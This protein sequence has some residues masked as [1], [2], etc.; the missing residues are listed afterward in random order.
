MLFSQS[1]SS[2]SMSRFWPG[3][4]FSE[5]T[6]GIV[7]ISSNHD[8]GQS[9]GNGLADL[10]TNSRLQSRLIPIHDHQGGLS[11]DR[12]IAHE[13][14]VRLIRDDAALV[15]HLQQL[16]NRFASVL[17][18]VESPF[19]HIHTDKF[20]GLLHVKIP[21]KLHGVLQCL[22]SVIQGVLDA[23]TQRI[24]TGIDQG[25]AKIALDRVPAQR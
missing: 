4:V 5:R 8:Y 21:G 19:V 10:E 2:A 3:K 23:V 20:V 22:F 18:V 9:A 24:A 17:A 7:S 1:V 15:S 6:A 13:L 16:T 12:S 25:R 14:N 11:R